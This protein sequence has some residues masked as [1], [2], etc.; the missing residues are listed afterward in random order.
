MRWAISLLVL[1]LT[2]GTTASFAINNSSCVIGL[3]DFYVCKFYLT[4]KGVPDGS[5]L[6][7]PKILIGD[8]L[9]QSVN[10]SIISILPYLPKIV[11]DKSN[12][13]SVAVYSKFV[14]GDCRQ[15][16]T[17]P[18]LFNFA[19]GT[20]TTVAGAQNGFWC[21]NGTLTL[22]GTTGFTKLVPLGSGSVGHPLACR[23]LSSLC[24]FNYGRAVY[25]LNDTGNYGTLYRNNMVFKRSDPCVSF[26]N[27]VYCNSNSSYFNSIS[28]NFN[29]ETVRYWYRNSTGDYLY[30]GTQLYNMLDPGRFNGTH[31]WGTFLTTDMMF[32]YGNPTFWVNFMSEA[33]AGTQTLAPG[34]MDY[35]SKFGAECDQNTGVLTTSGDGWL[36]EDRMI[37]S[38]FIS[39]NDNLAYFDDLETVKFGLSVSVI[40]SQV[41]VDPDLIQ[42][43][44]T[45]FG[46]LAIIYNNT[47]APADITTVLVYSNGPNSTK[48]WHY[49]YGY[50]VI[51]TTDKDVVAVC[52]GTCVS[53]SVGIFVS[54]P[55]LSEGGHNGGNDM[56]SII[57][58][59]LLYYYL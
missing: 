58:F 16:T 57:F 45:M 48:L 55:L 33:Q 59:L 20:G 34:Y 1:F 26:D 18:Y 12:P 25:G 29:A 54:E 56:A 50:G 31:Y 17:K 43:F 7:L 13:Q 10:T 19:Q 22:N 21:Y 53:V 42:A 8:V 51:R 36:T 52:I 2:A 39:W 27:D 40:Y 24:Y 5:I 35:C 3:G 23:E 41:F 30:V 46:E 28:D 32:I 49:D 47:E 38:P 37:K 44:Y 15:S 4:W 6:P 11:A 9:Y 14:E